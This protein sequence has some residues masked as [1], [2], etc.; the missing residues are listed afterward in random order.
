MSEIDKIIDIMFDAKGWG[1]PDTIEA[2]RAQL[3]KNLTDQVNGWWSGST[4]YYIMVNGGF[5][6]DGKPNTFK[7]LTVLGEMFMESMGGLKNNNV[8]TRAGGQ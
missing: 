6:I 2:K 7:K 1:I 8:N 4:A 5:L 3:H